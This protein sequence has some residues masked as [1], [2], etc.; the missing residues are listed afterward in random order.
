NKNNKIENARDIIEALSR[1]SE[2]MTS[3]L[4]LEDVLKLIVTVTAE[5]M[6]SKICSLM[7]LD[8][9][10][11]ELSIK[12]TQS[13]NKEY[14]NKNPLKLGEGIAGK[15]AQEGKPISVF[16]IAE[17]KNYKY[18]EIAH[19][20]GLVSLLCV[21]LHVKGKIIGVLTIYT[22]EPH[23]F[24]DYEVNILKTVADQAAIVIENYR[25]VME[26]RVIRE[27]LETRKAVERAK[28]ILMK[29]QNLNEEEAFRKIQ[30]F[31]MDNRRTMREVAEA[32][33]LSH[34]M[35]NL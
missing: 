26:T 2:A 31:S 20:E 17:D 14:I 27:E 7:L 24:S 34:E 21:P 5:V 12:A 22:S 32:I 1:I 19:R 28:G 23:H 29:E 13:I 25:L 10:K 3:D 15:V 8:P 30:K 11:K 4:Y 9:K 6:G 18:Q 33:V 16:N 35:K